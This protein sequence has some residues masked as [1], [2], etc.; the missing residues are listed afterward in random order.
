LLRFEVQH[1]KLI[2]PIIR[3]EVQ[4]F[5][6]QCYAKSYYKLKNVNTSLPAKTVDSV[7]WIGSD[8]FLNTGGYYDYYT[9]TMPRAAWPYSERRDSGYP[10]VGRGGYPTCKEWWSASGKG[11][12]NRLL[13]SFDKRTV[14]MMKAKSPVNWD[15][16]L[17]RWLVSPQN[18]HLSGGGDTYMMGNQQGQGAGIDT[19]IK[20]AL[21]GLGALSAQTTQLP[22]FDAHGAGAADGSCCFV[23]AIVVCPTGHVVRGLR[24]ESGGYRYFCDVCADIRPILVG[25]G[26]WL[27]DKLITLMYASYKGYTN[28]FNNWLASTGSDGW[29]M[30][31]VLGAMYV[32]LPM[33]WFGAVSWSGVQIGGA[34]S[35]VV[36]KA[37]QEPRTP[38]LKDLELLRM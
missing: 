3:Q 27:D 38:V 33:F 5:A 22:A 34:L 4:E 10:N 28:S 36:N 6:S 2:D 29:I 25:A 7:N 12:K 15:E 18:T 16:S 20:Q 30:N 14:N 32:M 11:L 9:S 19:G 23:M 1:T 37:T 21:S 26:G 31:L 35:S 17:L 8:Y 13:E 24:S